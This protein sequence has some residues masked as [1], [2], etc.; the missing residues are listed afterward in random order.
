MSYRTLPPISGTYQS[1]ITAPSN[2]RRWTGTQQTWP[3]LRFS[4][5]W[6]AYDSGVTGKVSQPD[7]N[8]IAGFGLAAAI[9]VGGWSG[10]ALLVG[11]LWK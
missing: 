11:Y 5:P 2:E 10:I 4:G 1:G 6:S 7:W 3:Q 8:R 9:S